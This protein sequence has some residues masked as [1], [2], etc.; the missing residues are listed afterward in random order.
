MRSRLFILF[1]ALASMSPWTG[2]LTRKAALPVPVPVPVPEIRQE[3]IGSGNGNGNGNGARE[4]PPPLEAS[5]PPDLVDDG[6]DDLKDPDPP[7]PPA[8]N[9]DREVDE[10][11][12]TA[13]ETWVFAE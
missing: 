10:L 9:P 4:Q 5:L 6:S 2:G 7:P 12:S 11:A 13:R 8:K 1:G 3:E